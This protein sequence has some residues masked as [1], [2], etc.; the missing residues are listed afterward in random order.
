M[1]IIFDQKAYQKQY[2]QLP[3]EKER[4]RQWRKDNPEQDKQW[5]ENNPEKVAI[6]KKLWREKNPNYHKEYSK[7][8]NKINKERYEKNNKKWREE[9]KEHFR[10]Y[11]N[12]YNLMW[13]K[14][15]KGKAV[16]QRRQFKRRAIFKNAI[17]TLTAKEWLDILEAYDYRCAYCDVEFN[18]ELP[19]TKDHVIPMSKGG[20]NTKE[21]IVPACLS[22]NCRKNDK[23]NYKIEIGVM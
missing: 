3:K 14:T 15:D 22:C 9:N 7:E 8:W 5:C 10:E 6:S 1:K 16:A 20:N 13:I 11:I 17:N 12:T 19:P 21:N 2:A 4:K 23:L 18:C